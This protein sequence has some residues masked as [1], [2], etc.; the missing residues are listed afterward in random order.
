MPI[1]KKRISIKK[2]VNQK[3]IEDLYFKNIT[4]NSK[5]GVIRKNASNLVFENVKINGSSDYKVA[6]GLMK[7]VVKK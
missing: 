2:T 6:G 1:N 4:V 7:A 5:Y 3:F